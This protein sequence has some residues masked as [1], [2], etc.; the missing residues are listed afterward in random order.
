MNFRMKLWSSSAVIIKP[1]SHYIGTWLE[2]LG[3]AEMCTQWTASPE[4]S[5]FHHVKG[6]L[7]TWRINYLMV[8]KEGLITS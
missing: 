1:V 8:I 3:T 7:I 4:S 2:M 5:W 6:G